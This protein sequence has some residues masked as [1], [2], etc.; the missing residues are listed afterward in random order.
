MYHARELIHIEYYNA[1]CL[2]ATTRDIASLS[3]QHIRARMGSGSKKTNVAQTP[4]LV[5]CPGHWQR[6][7]LGM[8]VIL[9]LCHDEDVFALHKTFANYSLDAISS[10]FSFW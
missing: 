1:Y 8:V 3:N 6:M 5:L 9:K 7:P 2:P 10:F 4:R